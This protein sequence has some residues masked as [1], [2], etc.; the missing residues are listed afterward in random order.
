MLEASRNKVAVSI[1]YQGNIVDLWEKLAEENISIDLG[2]D[3]T[4]LHNPFAGGYYPAGLSLE[5]SNR[6]MAENP[7]LFQEKV[8][9]SLCRQ[10]GNKST[11]AGQYSL[12]R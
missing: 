6:M 11:V 8:Y 4:S 9:E 1:A 7:A 3:Q 10:V 12:D 5:E 2:T